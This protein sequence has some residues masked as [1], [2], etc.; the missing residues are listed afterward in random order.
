MS[1]NHEE[2][3]LGGLEPSLR[4][5]TKRLPGTK[6]KN[7]ETLVAPSGHLIISA[8]LD[9]WYFETSVVR[10]KSALAWRNRGN[11]DKK[12]MVV[13][14]PPEISD[15]VI[16]CQ[17]IISY[18]AQRDAM[19]PSVKSPVRTEPARGIPRRR[20]ELFSWLKGCQAVP[21]SGILAHQNGKHVK[22]Q[23]SS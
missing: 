7:S 20:W 19:G 23:G 16:S 6:S 11:D 14:F 10:L 9:T 21:A 22:H 12:I 4:P 15:Q 8:N 1:L 13:L 5:E 18:A 2:L 17:G 3:E